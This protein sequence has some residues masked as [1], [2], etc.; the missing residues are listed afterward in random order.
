MA[1]DTDPEVTAI[2]TKRSTSLERLKQALPSL[3]VVFAATFVLAEWVDIVGSAER[4]STTGG[5]LVDHVAIWAAAK[6][7]LAGTP[8]L[9][10]DTDVL[11][12][13]QDLPE[14]TPPDAL[15]LWMY[16]PHAFILATPLGMLRFSL[17]FLIFS[18]VSL[19][20]WSWA[21][22]RP[23]AR[24]PASRLWL[25]AAPPLVYC[26]VT[27]QPSL[28]W[29]AGF[30]LAL[31]ALRERR[32]VTAGVILA[33]LTMKPHFGL[34]VPIALIA[35]GYWRT[36]AW[37]AAATALLLAVG[38]AMTGLEG[39]RGFLEAVSFHRSLIEHGGARVHHLLGV[40]PFLRTFGVPH[41]IA[42]IAQPATILVMAILVA[43][44]W[45]RGDAICFD[46]RAAVLCLA[47]YFA[48]PYAQFYDALFLAVAGLFWARALH[49]QGRFDRAARGLIVAGGVA[50]CF[51]FVPGFPITVLLTPIAAAA[52]IWLLTGTSTPQR[53]TDDEFPPRAEAAG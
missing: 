30:V 26:L 36:L 19:L 48:A 4:A 25:L 34:L 29:M 33:V 32:E 2:A 45:R 3:A 37:G 52:L 50:T 16:P 53:G 38:T 15:L 27:G 7:S 9:A 23:T 46:A 17:S 49:Q 8:A 14:G 47:G 24:L 6:L 28:L 22:A 41:D 21:I 5:Y 11:R 18:A 13:A 31:E 20:A 44:I 43:V 10:Y 35:G 12:V 40:Y 39:W 51:V 1:E 42:L